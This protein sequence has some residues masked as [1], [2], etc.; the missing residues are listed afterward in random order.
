MATVEARR[1]SKHFDEVRAVDGIDLTANESEFLVLLGPSGCGKTTLMRLIAGLERPT[2]GDIVIDGNI[3]TELPPRA[4][5]VAMV[6]QSY[7]L[8]PHLTVERNISFPLR[9]IGMPKDEI[10][11]KVD[12]A[13]RM[14]GIERFL[15][16]KPR[17]LSGGERQRVALA[18]AVVREPVVFLLDEPLSNLDA[19]LRNSAR[20]ELKQF[21]RTLRTTTIYVTHDQAEA[22]GLGDRIAVLNQGKVFQIGT[23]QDI[24]GEPVDTF[25]ATFIGSPPMNLIEDGATWLG[26][27]PEALLPRAVE[28]A[29]DIEIFPFRVTRIEYL[30]ADRLI[31]GVIEGRSP[32]TH[33]ISKLPT[34]IR[35]DITAG[36]AYE[37]VVRRTDV[38]RFDRASGRRVDGR[39]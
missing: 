2:A 35:T 39:G 30:G 4:R 20:D 21:Q 9:S 33:V 16:R 7:A 28:T 13:A 37:F 17:Q 24:Y 10:R 6:F 38:D 26:F 34:N 32:E 8:Y 25:V 5:N 14:F 22:M 36:E 1:V 19:K 12:W 23:P 31:Y 15:S 18:R 29:A 11:R 27:R 3:V